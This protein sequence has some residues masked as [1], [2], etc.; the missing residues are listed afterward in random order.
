MAVA[1]PVV[2]GIRLIPEARARRR[3]LC[4]WSRMLWVLVRSWMVV[5]EPWRMPSFSWITLT[6]GAR[7]LVVQDAAV[8]MRCSAALNRC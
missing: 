3:S 1:E 8:T 5:M 7:Q 4:G 6:T 2:V